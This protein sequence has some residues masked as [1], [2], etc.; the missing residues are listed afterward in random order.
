MEGCA[1]SK[2]ATTHSPARE[3]PT[4]AATAVWLSA[5]GF[6]MGSPEGEPGRDTD[7]GPRTHVALARFQM[8]V[9]PVTVRAFEERAEQVRA[10]D[11]QAHWWTEAETPQGWLGHCNLGSERQEH[12]MNCVDWRAARAYCELTGGALPTE[13]EWEYAARATA[14]TA[15]W[16]GETFDV[17]RVVSSV[18]CTSRGCLG[19]TAPVVSSG[20][21]CNSWGLC[22]MTGNVWQW[23]AT[24]YQE[25]LGETT[26]A[27]PP[28]VPEKPVHRGGSWLNQ[29][30][31]LFRSA[32]RGLAYPR[33]GLTGVGFR[34]VLRR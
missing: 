27:E 6:D 19:S 2:E 12:P 20:V 18:A 7:E 14:S 11:P 1:T 15:Y 26:P 31:S 34:C 25:H 30:P 32:H 8:D 3:A 33:N 21:R 23:T 29:V 4:T 28:D 5:G 22:D 16:W 10:K 24:T 17:T 13:A 9:T